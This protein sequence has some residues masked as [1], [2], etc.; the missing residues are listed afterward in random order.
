[1]RHGLLRG[2]QDHQL[3]FDVKSFLVDLAIGFQDFL[4]GLEIALLER[5]DRIQDCLLHHTAQQKHI[6]L[7]L[8]D[9]SFKR[10]AQH[11]H[12]DSYSAPI[13]SSS[14]PSRDIILGAFIFRISKDNI[15]RSE[16]H[17]SELQ[18]PTNLVCRLLL[19]KK[20]K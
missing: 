2:D 16:E 10:F 4:G 19:E 15:R 17:T 13:I 5:L 1:M 11:T 18:S 14:K 20:K 7:D 6:V 8:F 3:I 12:L 9:L